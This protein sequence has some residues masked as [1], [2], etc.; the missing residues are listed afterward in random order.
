MGQTEQFVACIS[1]LFNDSYLHNAN[2]SQIIK[3][4]SKAGLIIDRFFKISVQFFYSLLYLFEN[5]VTIKQDHPITSIT[6]P[7]YFSSSPYSLFLF[8]L[9]IIPPCLEHLAVSTSANTGRRLLFP[10]PQ[11]QDWSWM[12][13]LSFSCKLTP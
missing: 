13:E 3:T 11:I 6:Y 10:T 1:K 5:Y 2:Q 8:S 7:Y 4:K 12:G 9:M